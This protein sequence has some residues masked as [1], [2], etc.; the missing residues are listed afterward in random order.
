MTKNKYW[1]LSII[2]LIVV[3]VTGGI[4][5]WARYHPPQPI[6]ISLPP[7]PQFQGEVYIDGAVSNPGFY[8]LQSDDSIEALIRVA[9]GTTDNADLTQLKLYIPSVGEEQQPQKIDINRA[10]GWLLTA[11]PGIG[12]TLAQRIIDY[13]Q[14]NGAFRNISEITNVVGIGPDNYKQ[15]KNLITVAD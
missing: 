10:E 14:Q 8:P 11:L 5:A 1:A 4:I 9:G 13:R 3:I 12:E 7:S 15:I 6:E 2:L